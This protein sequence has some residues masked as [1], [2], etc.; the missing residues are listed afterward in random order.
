MQ[1]ITQ[2]NKKQIFIPSERPRY[3]GGDTG[4]SGDQ[5]D[6]VVVYIEVMKQRHRHHGTNI[7]DKS[8]KIVLFVIKVWVH[9][10]KPGSCCSKST[11]E[12]VSLEK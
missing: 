3:S 11:E 6:Q 7:A 10:P 4:Q 8:L 5:D 2:N 12:V 1:N 9:L